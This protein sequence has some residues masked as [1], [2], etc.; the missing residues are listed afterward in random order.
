MQSTSGTNIKKNKEFTI[1][2]IFGENMQ[3]Q[4]VPQ[5]T[6]RPG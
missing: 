4:Y 2:C 1:M 5:V 3:K 6:P